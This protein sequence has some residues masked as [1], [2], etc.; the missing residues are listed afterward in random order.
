MARATLRLLTAIVIIVTSGFTVAEGW[1]IVRFFLTG[2]GIVSSGKRAV[3]A[4]A[5]QARSGVISTALLDELDEE[6]G[7][8]DAISAY[9]QRELLPALLSIKPMSSMAWFLLSSAE[10]T[11]HRS[12]E[13]V[14][15]SLKLSML[16]GPNEAYVMVRRGVFGLSLWEQLPPDLK[17]GVANDLIPI[18]FWRTPAEG[19][20]RGK[21]QAILAAEPEQA[22]A[23]IRK[24]LLAVGLSQNDIKQKVGF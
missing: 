19:A 16:T 8:S 14:L 13:D 18:L 9:H 5:L 17:G 23:E 12:I 15:A 21:L 7:R 11:T 22:R 2:V 20:E 1:G 6:I 10:L 3:F 24:A 4:D